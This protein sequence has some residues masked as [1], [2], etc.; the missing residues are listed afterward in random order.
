MYPANNKK[1]VE[2][3]I[4]L[5]RMSFSNASAENMKKF[6]DEEDL[7]NQ[8]IHNSFFSKKGGGGSLKEGG[9]EHESGSESEGENGANANL[10]T[11]S[12]S[13]STTPRHSFVINHNNDNNAESGY[14]SLSEETVHIDSSKQPHQATKKNTKDRFSIRT[15]LSFE[16]PAAV[17]IPE[18]S[19]ANDCWCDA[20]A[21][22]NRSSSQLTSPSSVASMGSL[23][24][25][26]HHHAGAGE[27]KEE[28]SSL[29]VRNHSNMSSLSVDTTNNMN[30]SNYHYNL[31]R[32]VEDPEEQS[33]GSQVKTLQRLGRS[34]LIQNSNKQQPEKST[35]PTKTN[36]SNLKISLLPP[37]VE[38]NSSNSSSAN[39]SPLARP[40]SQ[41]TMN[42]QKQQQHCQLVSRYHS[43]PIVTMNLA[44]KDADEDD[45]VSV[46]QLSVAELKV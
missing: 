32:S 20:S 4:S 10:H 24:S 38:Q 30:D 9:G 15:A 21:M 7:E 28:R 31:S 13:S 23:S 22:S 37:L 26:H 16:V 1:K 6:L 27:E 40:S 5:L 18:R 44:T 29:H 42:A 19:D 46:S 41:P 35:I 17:I 25:P 39:S 33:H 36:I 43:S 11:S 3:T 45:N 34:F 8:S 2:P 12:N 14:L